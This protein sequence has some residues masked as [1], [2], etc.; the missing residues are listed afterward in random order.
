MHY[1]LNPDHSVKP[2]DLMEWAEYFGRADRIVAKTD[3]P[4]GFHIS[5][6]FIGL[7]H[8]FGNGPLLL[9]ETMVFPGE[10]MNRYSTWDEAVAGHQAMIDKWSTPDPVRKGKR[11]LNAR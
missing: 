5:T 6:V 9:F 10:D 11:A 8:Q 1:I 3:L 2:C 7:D 4:N